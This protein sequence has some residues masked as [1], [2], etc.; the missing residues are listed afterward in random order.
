MSTINRIIPTVEYLVYI[1]DIIILIT[2]ARLFIGESVTLIT[3][4]LVSISI[5]YLLLFLLSNSYI[6][7]GRRIRSFSS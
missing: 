5:I 3:N 7:R 2:L 1:T 6:S 4:S